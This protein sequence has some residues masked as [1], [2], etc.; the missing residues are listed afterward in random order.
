MPNSIKAVYQSNRKMPWSIGDRCGDKPEIQTPDFA[1]DAIPITTLRPKPTSTLFEILLY[2]SLHQALGHKS[3]GRAFR[4]CM[5]PSLA[6]TS[7]KGVQQGA[8]VYCS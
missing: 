1:S 2:T 5:K 4:L 8:F 3:A 6:H 7:Y